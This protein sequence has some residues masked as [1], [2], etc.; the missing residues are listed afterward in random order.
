MWYQCR[1]HTHTH[2][3]ISICINIHTYSYVDAVRSHDYLNIILEFVENGAVSSLLKRFDGHL[4]ESLCKLYIL[5]VLTGLNYLHQQGVIHRDIKGAY[6][7]GNM[8]I[9]GL[10]LRTCS[11]LLPD[12]V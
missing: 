1:E 2:T 11:F 3:Y 9:H 4:P 7:C 8:C 12:R 6:V 5:Q 10:C